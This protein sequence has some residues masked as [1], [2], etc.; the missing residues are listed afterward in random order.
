MFFL[1]VLYLFI[2]VFIFFISFSSL[3]IYY[4]L[5]IFSFSSF[6]F[7]CRY[8]YRTA[9]SS[10]GSSSSG[11]AV[12]PI[13]SAPDPMLLREVI[14]NLTTLAP[15][16]AG[17]VQWF[18]WSKLFVLHSNRLKGVKDTLSSERSRRQDSDREYNV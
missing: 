5:L 2:C 10:G 6:F 12:S 9:N 15:V 14:F 7:F 1:L 16:I 11:P 8:G 13:L 4:L 18:V 3:F 17:V